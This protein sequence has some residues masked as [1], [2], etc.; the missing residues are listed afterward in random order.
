MTTKL[1][2]RTAG[3]VLVPFMLL[4][5]PAALADVGHDE[6]PNIGQAGDVSH[7]DRVI[8]V[9]MGEMYFTPDN[10]TFEA[11]ETV[12]FNLVNSGR[13][14]HEFALGTDAMQDAHEREMRTM[15]RSGMITTRE[16]RHD[17]MLEAGMMHVDANSRL[18][19]PGGTAE[20]IWTF[21][22]DQEE[23]ILIACNV[24]GHRAAGMVASVTITGDH[25]GS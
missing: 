23:P 10:Y 11:G 2:I 12:Q 9:D 24:P 15:M 13:A 7:I 22:G 21:S 25:A 6:M 4:G 18:L 8:E 16:L 20:L 19:E 1:A 17:R 3:A 14:V 5:A